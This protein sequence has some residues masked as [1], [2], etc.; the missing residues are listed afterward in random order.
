MRFIITEEQYD[1]I[2]DAQS[3]NWVRRNYDLVKQEL[4]DT[5]QLMKDDI[6]RL[7]YENFEYHFFSVLMDGLHPHFYD[8]EGFDY[9]G[10]FNMLIDLFYV[11]CTEFYFS[12][13]EK[14]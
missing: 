2:I 4:D 7:D 9:N 1:R 5:Y 6:C 14:C 11:D 10:V 8:I 13:R 3:R 12:G